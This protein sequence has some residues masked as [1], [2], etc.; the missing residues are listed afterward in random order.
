MPARQLDLDGSA[1]PPADGWLSDEGSV[2]AASCAH[3]GWRSAWLR[4]PLPRVPGTS[5]L[6][7]AA[8]NLC[9]RQAGTDRTRELPASHC[10]LSATPGGSA[11]S[12]THTV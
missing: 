3:P 5:H 1:V 4:A 10:A 7:R 11:R 8:I 12:L 2:Q 6:P 9:G